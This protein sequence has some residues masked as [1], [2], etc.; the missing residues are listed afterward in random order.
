MISSTS[1]EAPPEERLAP[2]E[3]PCTRG[4]LICEFFKTFA[5]TVGVFFFLVTFIIQGYSVYGSCMEP[6]LTTG[7]RVLGNKFIYHFEKPSRGDIVIFKYPMN[8]KKI[9]V[10]RVI[11]LPGDTVR[12][13]DGRVFINHQPI[14]ESAYVRNPAN[15]SWPARTI[16]SDSIFVLGDN[17]DNS[18]D[19]R[20]W[21]DLPLNDIQAKAWL[22]YWPI[23]RAT[24]L[25]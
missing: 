1:R 6:N 20:S 16:S 19:S 13:Q 12:I 25:K 18:N 24:V 5:V 22:R 14:N 7:E 21:G 2:P 4:Y 10:K 11:G 17:R 3:P 8:P 9:F 23:T 15:G